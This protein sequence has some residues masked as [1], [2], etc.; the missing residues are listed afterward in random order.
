MLDDISQQNLDD[1]LVRR[2]S[3]EE[4]DDLVV[5]G[6]PNLDDHFGGFRKGGVYILGGI[7]K[8]G[9]TSFTLNLVAQMMTIGNSVGYVST[10]MVEKNVIDRIQKICGIKGI[11]DGIELHS[12][13][14]DH[15]LYTG[16]DRQDIYG[17]EKKLSFEKLIAKM[18]Q[19]IFQ[20]AKLI[21]LDNLTTFM[22]S[23][24]KKLGWEAL[25]EKLSLLISLAQRENV[26][27][28]V[29]LH[30]KTS[31]AY[32]ETPTGI[33]E[34]LDNNSPHAVFEKSLS[35]VRRPT[36]SDLYGGNL[37]QV[38]GILLI[39]R[40]FQRFKEPKLREMSLVIIDTHRFGSGGI[41]IEMEYEEET[42]RFREIISSQDIEK[43]M[44]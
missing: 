21:I 29:L 42:G 2:K 14:K 25:Q 38:T 40:P 10:E 12:Q 31:T 1:I 18:E 4:P 36:S 20:G 19:F 35:F 33:R 13:M 24:Q 22:V 37:S 17:Q 30:V 43:I 27:I 32:T 41:D 28:L 34:L 15:W 7:E 3:L 26:P 9:K 8:C 6:F 23:S 39:W 44:S 5:T 11:A 16:V